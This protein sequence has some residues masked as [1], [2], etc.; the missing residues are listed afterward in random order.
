MYF[1]N[2]SQINFIVRVD[3]FPQM[4]GVYEFADY[5]DVKYIY[6]APF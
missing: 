3:F 1:R 4:A 2:R 6:Q 5:K